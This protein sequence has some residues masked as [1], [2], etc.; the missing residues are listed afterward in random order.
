VYFHQF[1]ERL[2][3]HDLQFFGES[4]FSSMI[5]RNF[6]APVANT[7][8]RGISDVLRME[9]YMDSSAT[10][11]SGRRCSAT[12]SSNS[13]GMST[14]RVMGL[15]VA[16][17]VKEDREAELQTSGHQALQGVERRTLPDE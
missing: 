1:A 2:A 14:A 7:L 6:A 17:G 4:E 5:V 15:Y 3:R 8:S 9:Q 16:A 10:A 12:V 13:T 11:C